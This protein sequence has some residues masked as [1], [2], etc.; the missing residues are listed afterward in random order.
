MSKNQISEGL[1]YSL[2]IAALIILIGVLV[3]ALF[4]LLAAIECMLLLT[5]AGW[6]MLSGILF[7]ESVKSK[8]KADEMERN[9]ANSHKDEFRKAWAPYFHGM[10]DI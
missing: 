10:L 9:F 6:M 8:R 5:Y 3:G 2:I 7:I 4:E 1:G